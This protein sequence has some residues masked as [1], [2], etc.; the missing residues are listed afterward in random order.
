MEGRQWLTVPELAELLGTTPRGI[1][2]RTSRR[3]IPFVRPVF[4][5][6][7]LFDR[8]E[9]DA[10]LLEGPKLETVELPNGGL[11]VRPATA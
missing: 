8:A 11:R 5:R 2:E 1:W 9:I 10:W 3:A 4:S 7:I 6:K